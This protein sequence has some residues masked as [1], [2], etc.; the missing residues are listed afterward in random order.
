MKELSSKLLALT[1]MLGI[2]ASQP[3]LAQSG[4]W[5]NDAS[6]NW[7]G[8]ANWQNAV[9]ADGAGNTAY[10]SNSI[11]AN[12]SITND[13]S[14]TIGNLEFGRPDIFVNSG[15]RSWTFYRTGANVLTLDNGASVPTI[16]CWKGAASAGTS[17]RFS[18]PLSSS[19]GLIKRGESPLW[20]NA[21]NPSLNGTLIIA[22]GSV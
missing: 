4:S 18:A 16:T 19:L 12:R 17:H 11:S 21:A 1:F 15:A 8:S 20:L 6:G 13:T 3:L 10:F 5:T 22:D 14:R 9:V 7:G 2:G